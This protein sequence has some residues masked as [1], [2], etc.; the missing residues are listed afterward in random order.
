MMTSNSLKRP[1]EMPCC[2]EGEHQD[3]ATIK[4]LHHKKGFPKD[5]FISR[6]QE[7][8]RLLGLRLDKPCSAPPQPLADR[9]TP[10]SPPEHPL[11]RQDQ[12]TTPLPT[13]H[14]SHLLGHRSSQSPS[15]EESL[16]R[17][18]E[19]PV[20]L[21]KEH[22]GVTLRGRGPR[23]SQS[24]SEEVPQPLPET[25]EH[26]DTIG[27]RD[28]PCPPS[29]AEMGRHQCKSTY[30]NMKN[31]TSPESSPPPK[32]RPEHCNVDKAEENDLK[33]S[34][35]KMIEE[36]IK[37]KMPLKKLKKRQTKNWRK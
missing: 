20:T 3:S 27:T 37:G 30:N 29:K 12:K 24:S 5:V 34:L 10:P 17:T 14:P 21:R 15:V 1:T 19:Q 22:P 32:P 16:P 9:G 2:V 23:S 31:K 26:P 8:A 6:K 25:Q 35:M 18:Q 33:N 11:K 36:A 13:T 28:L 4:T 7:R